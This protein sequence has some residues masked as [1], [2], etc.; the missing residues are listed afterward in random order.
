[1]ATWFDPPQLFRTGVDVVLSAVFGS[2]ADYR[3]IEGLGQPQ[4]PFVY[5]ADDELWLDYVAD[6]GDGWNPTYAVALTAARP[7]L[8][9]KS[10]SGAE[11]VTQRARVL[12]F[13]GDEVYPVAS[14]E[15]Y[16]ARL[17]RPYEAALPKAE[18]RPHVYALPGNHDW[19]DGLNAFCHVFCAG[20]PFGAW[21]TRQLRSYFALKLPHRWWLLGVDV[22]LESDIDEA[23]LQYF[24]AV[25]QMM[26]QGDGVVLCTAEP[27]WVYGNIYH[28]K[29]Q[30]HLAELESFVEAAGANVR[31]RLAGDLHH[32]QHHVSDA[33]AH[34][35]VA[36]GGGAFLHPT[37]G[38]SRRT[39]RLHR[40]GPDGTSR[41]DVYRRTRGGVWPRP[42]RTR[43][44]AAKALAFP[45]LNPSFGL[46]TA[47]LYAI[48]STVL[49]RPA[50]TH[51]PLELLER[52]LTQL[53]LFPS[54]LLWVGLTLS[55]F[56]LFTD[57]HR[58]LYRVLGGATHGMAHLTAALFL[59][60]AADRLT[61]S[62]GLS[63]GAPSQRG[64]ALALVAGA[65]YLVG[66]LIMGVYLFVSSVGFGRH[67]NESFGALR[68]E[69]FKNFLRLHIGKDGALTVYPVG[70]EKVPTG[71]RDAN[72]ADGTPRVEPTR[73]IRPRLIEEPFR[74]T[75][76]PERAG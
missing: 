27:D 37:H 56:V 3:R 28:P 48:F 66:A 76:Q 58:R 11:H 65:G 35:V 1:M 9:L 72:G 21:E 14:R 47:V 68:I 50:A 55:A 41:V 64:A 22:Q 24:R 32:Y 53:V 12:V 52:A 23:Q 45:V 62:W 36:G 17:L 7:T 75:R 71:W 30:K 51:G 19:Y 13:G 57:T 15:S 31:L 44:M 39:I 20:R 26:R 54:A 6:T 49:P 73:P 8:T 70:L 59:T 46:A 33:G 16:D 18:V 40:R 38:Y 34:N 61:V 63:D 69:G 42:A 2:R 60:H 67:G 25:T 29:M 74:V 43:L 4:P 10:P 5:D